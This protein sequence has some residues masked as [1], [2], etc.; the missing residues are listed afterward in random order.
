MNSLCSQVLL[1]PIAKQFVF[2]LYCQ[3]CLKRP[4]MTLWLWSPVDSSSCCLTG[5]VEEDEGGMTGE[6]DDTGICGDG[7]VFTSLSGLFCT[8]SPSCEIAE[9]S[10][11]WLHLGF[12][13]SDRSRGPSHASLSHKDALST[14]H[15]GIS[16]FS[17]GTVW[18]STC[19]CRPFKRNTTVGSLAGGWEVLGLCHECPNACLLGLAC[20]LFGIK[21]G[22]RGRFSLEEGC[23]TM[24][25]PVGATLTQSQDS[26]NDQGR[27][28][29]L[30]LIGWGRQGTGAWSTCLLSPP[31]EEEEFLRRRDWGGIEDRWSSPSTLGALSYE[32]QRPDTG[33]RGN[34]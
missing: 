12:P 9:S 33:N 23:N 8:R 6:G 4:K 28:P 34:N 10:L 14:L 18:L 26:D 3:K 25:A 1:Q 20:W 5:G 21:L 15:W 11:V 19:S 27:A 24:L 2:Q 30:L 32:K 16:F 31:A 7:F 29:G 13:R 22:K 17:C